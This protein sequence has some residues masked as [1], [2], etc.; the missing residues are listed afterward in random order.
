VRD[1]VPVSAPI[2]RRHLP[3]ASFSRQIWA[4]F[5]LHQDMQTVLRCHIAAFEAIDSILMR[6]FTTA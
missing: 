2:S 3:G 6:P 4:R 1:R 5:V